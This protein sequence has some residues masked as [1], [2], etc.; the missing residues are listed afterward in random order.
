MGTKIKIT[1]ELDDDFA[2]PDHPTGVTEEAS[3]SITDALNSFGFDID[4]EK[5]D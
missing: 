4:I 5:E 2:D 3:E 1:M